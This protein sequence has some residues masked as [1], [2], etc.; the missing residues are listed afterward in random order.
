[1]EDVASCEQ[2]DDQTPT[3]CNKQMW[4]YR[5]GFW[6]VAP[7]TEFVHE[8]TEFTRNSPAQ[9]IPELCT[10]VIS[11][12]AELVMLYLEPK[13]FDR[14]RPYEEKYADDGGTDKKD[15]ISRLF[16]DVNFKPSVNLQ[17][18]SHV[19]RWLQDRQGWS[20]FDETVRLDDICGLPS[21]MPPSARFLFYACMGGLFEANN[22]FGPKLPCLIGES[23]WML[24]HVLQACG[25]DLCDLRHS[26]ESL[27]G[28]Q[29]LEGR[30]A[31]IW[32]EFDRTLS[33]NPRERETT[34]AETRSLAV[35][36]P[37]CVHRKFGSDLVIK[38]R[39][40][41]VLTVNSLRSPLSVVCGDYESLLFC[42]ELEKTKPGVE[43]N[44]AVEE[45]P[46]WIRKVLFCAQWLQV[47]LLTQNITMEKLL[48]SL[49][50]FV[51]T[52]DRFCARIQS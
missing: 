38:H 1:M 4:S 39:M 50:Y 5:N 13:P 19:M 6:K 2:G 37:I 9:I 33:D 18:A 8:F 7:C 10:H 41:G 26:G 17:G 21:H 35:G 23:T 12:L 45:L 24:H 28:L 25:L 29:A 34:L 31:W 14:F 49:P 43:F 46:S 22:A 20:M 16:I 47:F 32:S 11:D 42:F 40:P 36:E 52:H 3:M 51:A 15:G 30:D 44:D 48:D 27:F